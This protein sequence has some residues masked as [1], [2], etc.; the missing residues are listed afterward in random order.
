MV[1]NPFETLKLM[2]TKNILTG[3]LVEFLCAQF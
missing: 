2:I 1:K 3:K